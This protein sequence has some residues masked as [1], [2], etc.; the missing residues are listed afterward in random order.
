[1][2]EVDVEMLKEAGLS[3]D[4]IA[5]VLKDQAKQRAKEIADQIY[6]WPEIKALAERLKK[7]KADF[8]ITLKKEGES[9]K[10]TIK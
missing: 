4:Q 3:E 2:S 7:G 6:S 5:K 9:V 1:M 8:A 10:M